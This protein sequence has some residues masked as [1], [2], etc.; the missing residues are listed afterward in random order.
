MNKLN[1]NPLIS[2]GSI[3]LVGT[4]DTNKII[5]SYKELGIDVIRFFKGEQNISLY[6]CEKTGYR[7]YYP[8]D[9][10]GDA[11]FYKDLSLNRENYYSTRWEHLEIIDTFKSDEK[12]LEIGSGFGAFL[13]LLKSK[14]IEAEGLE[15]NPEA[16]KQCKDLGLKIHNELIDTFSKKNTEQFD[17]VC[18]FQVLEHVTNVHEF[19]K[20][21]LKTLKVG[22]KLVIGVPNSN[23]YL[24]VNDK[25]HTL[26]LP[27]HHAGLWNSSSLRAL[28]EIFDVKLE[29]INYEPLYKT[30]TEFLNAYCRNSNIIISTSLSIFNKIVPKILKKVLCRFIKGRNILVVFRKGAI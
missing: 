27:P 29:S 8:F 23:P 13:N 4:F 1:K 24:F 30:Y 3:R 22:G 28:E 19:I 21:S 12:V 18:Y 25:Y 16:I 11:E 17:V 20:A 2:N 10:I 9:S 26:N 7:F 6:K 5:S 14:N 15:L